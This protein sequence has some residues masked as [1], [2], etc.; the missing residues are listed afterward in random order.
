MCLLLA[1]CGGEDGGGGATA[2]PVAALTPT[3]V[4]VTPAPAA[5][6]PA[7]TGGDGF[8]AASNSQLADVD[9][10]WTEDAT[11]SYFN[12]ALELPWAFEL[13]AWRDRN[14]TS[15][16]TLPF[17]SVAF[18]DQPAEQVVHWDVTDL[19]R[20][21]GADFMI[22]RSGGTNAVFYSREASDPAKRPRLIISRP[23]GL[24]TYTA[25]AD[26]SLNSTTFK[27]QGTL[28]RLSSVGPMLVKFDVG[29]DAG[30]SRAT[31]ELT[32]TTEQ[33]GNQTLDV[34]HTD[35]RPKPIEAPKLPAASGETVLQLSGSDWESKAIKFLPDRMTTNADGSLTVRIP[36]GGETGAATYYSIPPAA[37]S[38]VMFARTV[39]KVHSDWTAPMGG[40]FP[41]L[42][43]TGQ[44][45]RRE[46]R[47]GWGGRLGDGVC[48]SARTNRQGYVANTPFADTHLALQPYIYRLNRVTVNGDTAPSSRAAPKGRFFV[49]D[50]MVKLNSIG[51]DGTPLADGEIAYWLNGELINR[52]T[53]I[54][55]RKRTGDDTLP[56]EYW[57]DVYE[58][59]TGYAAPR[60]HTVTFSEVRISNQLLP[61]DAAA[62]ARLNN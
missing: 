8:T 6:A 43:N 26:T 58:G 44:G 24:Q 13:G 35:V 4:E 7:P 55:W 11:R 22:R 50:Q 47:C 21:H 37:R 20:R 34:F 49:L 14:G 48:W 17:A 42:S 57:L 52:M 54:I 53:G 33:F 31:L 3:V 38:E 16:G 19:I 40:K 5:P 45:D 39:M 23:S 1:A 30:I 18:V 12:A 2:A 60:D 59:G 62:L 25:I 15:Q 27:P 28:D 51:A 32:A 29:A 36:T 61:F 56:S 41:G 46:E 10:S 9:A